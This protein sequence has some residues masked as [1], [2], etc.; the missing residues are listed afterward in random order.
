MDD[1]IPIVRVVNTES[2]INSIVG[3]M[4]EIFQQKTLNAN[5]AARGWRVNLFSPGRKYLGKSEA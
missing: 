1:P 3:M 4:E 2:R 5:K